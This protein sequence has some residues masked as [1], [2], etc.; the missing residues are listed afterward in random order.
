MTRFEQEFALVPEGARWTAALVCLAV[1][2]LM[3]GLFLV[4]G[5]AERDGTAVLV[6]AA[7]LPRRPSSAWRSSG[8]TCSSWATSSGTRGGAR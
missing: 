1:T 2:A 4:P 7:R 3:A 8:P 5:L 6:L